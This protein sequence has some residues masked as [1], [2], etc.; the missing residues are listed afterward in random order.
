PLYHFAAGDVAGSE[1]YLSSQTG[2]LLQ[3]TT[4]SER[5]WGYLGA[6]VHWLYPTLLRER[7][8]LWSQTVIWLTI[9]TLVLVLSGMF[10]GLTQFRRRAGRTS[11]Y[12]G[13]SR[14]HHFGG[15]IFGV[16]A[17]TWLFSGLFSM[18]PLGILSGSSARPQIDLLSAGS[19]RADDLAQILAV[20]PH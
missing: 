7:V 18:Q 5:V 16:L 1:W 19:I 6:V 3:M 12:R 17:F 11:P 20:L 2:E 4:R 14:W 13:L 15:I 8:Q 10:F 9:L